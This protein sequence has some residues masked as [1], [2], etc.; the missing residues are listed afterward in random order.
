MKIQCRTSSEMSSPWSG[1]EKETRPGRQTRGRERH[2]AND[3]GI[4]IPRDEWERGCRV[5][6]SIPIAAAL[7]MCVWGR[8]A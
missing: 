3:D 7:M 6:A 5:F 2:R 4:M 1:L 8:V